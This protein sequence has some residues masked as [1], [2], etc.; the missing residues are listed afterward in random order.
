MG[1]GE[2]LII[3]ASIASGLV[4]V[5]L[6]VVIMWAHMIMRRVSEMASMDDT[7]NNA[8]HETRKGTS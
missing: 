5:W 1:I 8:Y 4:I 6:L 3:I 7:S 2:A